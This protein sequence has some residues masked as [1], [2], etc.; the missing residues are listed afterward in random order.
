MIESLS[1]EETVDHSV[2][3][4]RYKGVELHNC[5]GKAFAGCTIISQEE[6]VFILIRSPKDVDKDNNS[7]PMC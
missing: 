3:H 1:S 7:F 6:A 2:R 4:T 5:S